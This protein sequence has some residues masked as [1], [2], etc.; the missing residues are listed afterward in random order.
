MQKGYIKIIIPI[1]IILVCASTFMVG[2]QTLMDQLFHVKDLI[3]QDK[4][5]EA[6]ALLNEIESECL[7][8][9]NDTILLLFNESKGTILC[10]NNNFDA[11]IPYMERVP[12]LYESLNIK[13]VNYIEAYLALGI[14]YQKRHD[15]ETAERYYRRGLLSSVTIPNSAEYQSSFYLNLGNM[16]KEQGD[17]L[18]AQECF[19]RI[20]SKSFGQLIDANSSELIEMSELQALEYRKNGESEKALPIYERLIERTREILG[21]HNEEYVRLLFNKGMILGVDLGRYNEARPIYKEVIGLAP[22]LPACDEN[23]LDSFQRYL[24]ILAYNGETDE[25]DSMFP[26]VVDRFR[27]CQSDYISVGMLARM[28][29]NG[30][31]WAKRY[32]LAIPYYELYLKEAP[33]ED[34]NSFLEIPNMLSVCYIMTDQPIKAKETLASLL[35]KQIAAFES[36]TKIYCTVLHNYGRSV[37]L[38]GNHKDAIPYFERANDL[39]RSIYGQDNPKTLEYL[40]ECK[41]H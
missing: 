4:E 6:L 37:M 23:V 32:E 38:L 41:K 2:A 12:A 15:Y 13:G 24:Q 35:A 40:E 9:D 11:S 16:Y 3:H 19:K 39:F 33:T 8:S 27:N 31:Y 36:N 10:L 22:F 18:L 21:S 26:D 17:S 5:E 34:G 28:V 20:D 1:L 25:L 30:A 14:A 7:H 29:G